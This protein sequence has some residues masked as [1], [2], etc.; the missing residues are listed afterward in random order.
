MGLGLTALGGGCI[1]LTKSVVNRLTPLSVFGIAL[2]NIGCLLL[3]VCAHLI[4]HLDLTDK[5]TVQAD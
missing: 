2:I 5:T 4:R 3:S 1:A